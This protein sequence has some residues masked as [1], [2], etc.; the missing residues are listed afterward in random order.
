MSIPSSSASVDD[1]AEQLAG[2]PAAPR[3]RA[4]AAACSRRGR[5]RSAPRARRGR[6]RSSSSC[7]KLRHQLDGLARL[8]EHD[9]ARALAHEL[10]EQVGRLGQ[11]RAPRGELLVD[12]RRVPHR[13]RALGARER[14]RGRPRVMSSSP[15][16]RSASSPGL[17]IVRR[18]EQE[19]RRRAVG[20]ADPPQPPQHVG[21]VRA[22][23]AA[24]DVRLVDHDHREVGEEVA[25]RVVVG[26]DPEVQHVG[27]GEDDVRPPP[28][29][30]PLL[31]RRVAVVDRRARARSTP[32]ACSAR[33]WSWA[34]AFVGYR[35][36]ARARGVAAQHVERRQV[37]AQRLAGRGAGGDDRR[38]RP[39][40]VQRLGLVAPTASRSRAPRSASATVGCSSSGIAASSRRPGVLRRLHDEPLVLASRPAGAASQGSMSRTI[41]TLPC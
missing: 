9:R 26:Q 21:D 35:Y 11:R 40:R 6:A 24:V 19:A 37:E 27:V 41:A 31:A 18:R 3:A 34:S 7:A 14:R 23:H 15:V 30:R 8:H 22:E 16:S 5:A 4:A 10:G 36:S 13:D 1:D 29:R 32:S 20:V 25:P 2:R 33:A 38:P 28:D 17:A 12:D 39:R